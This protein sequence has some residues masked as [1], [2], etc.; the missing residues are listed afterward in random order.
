MNV[1]KLDFGPLPNSGNNPKLSEFLSFAPVLL[2]V[3]NQRVV[4]ELAVTATADLI[5]ELS[6]CSLLIFDENINKYSL[7]AHHNNHLLSQEENSQYFSQL[8]QWLLLPHDQPEIFKGESLDPELS[9]LLG[10]KVNL[11]S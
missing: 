6:F 7:T 2:R 1:E 11:A 4:T 5:A 3:Q 8:P 9:N 10:A